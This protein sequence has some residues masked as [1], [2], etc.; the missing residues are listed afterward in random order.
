MITVF[1]NFD[2][3]PVQINCTLLSFSS[4]N[5]PGGA[6]TYTLCNGTVVNTSIQQGF[7]TR[8]TCIQDGSVIYSPFSGII[9]TPHGTC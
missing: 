6:I 9:A 2:S 5:G 7:T 4:P 1:S 8:P 3:P